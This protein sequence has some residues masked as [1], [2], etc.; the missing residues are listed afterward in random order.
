MGTK[1]LRGRPVWEMPGWRIVSCSDA[2][3]SW[4]EIEPPDGTVEMNPA[5]ARQLAEA[6]TAVANYTADCA[7][8]HFLAQPVDDKSA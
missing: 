8:Q 6:L 2:R 1:K 4:V 7:V 5:T 3:H